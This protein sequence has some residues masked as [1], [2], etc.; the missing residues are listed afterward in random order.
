MVM[1]DDRQH[2]L[3]IRYMLLSVG[4]AVA[5]IGL[6]SAAALLTGSVG[7]LSDAVES[8]VNLVAA[9]VG[10]IALRAAARPPDD[11]HHFGH[12]N[13]EYLSAAI[14]GTMI[15]VAAL[16][17]IATSVHRLIY[18]SPFQSLGIGLGLSTIAAGVNLVVGLL[19]I[20]VGREHRSMTL[21][22][23]G[24]HLMTDVWTTAGVLVGIALVAIFHWETLDPLIGLVVGLNIVRVGYGLLRRST[25]GLLDAALSPTDAAKVAEVIDRYRCE[26]LID[27]HA[28]RTQESGRQRFVYVDVHVPGSWTVEHAH[29]VIDQFETDIAAVLPGVVTF[30]HLEP[31]SHAI[32]PSDPR[33][34]D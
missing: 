8:V 9:V 23:D 21:E 1:I 30:T 19:L 11:I 24:K 6:K 3:L 20:R 26:R 7:F 25:S 18:P 34:K 22:A 17:I 5:T 29:D 32:P 2:R 16:A 15:L 4:A 33:L 12:G 27:F 10:L 13:A 14:E 28:L 31:A